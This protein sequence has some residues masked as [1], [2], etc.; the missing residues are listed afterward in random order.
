MRRLPNFVVIGAMK[1]GTTSLHTYLRAHPDVF[2]PA[3]KELDFFDPG[4]TWHRGVDW[5]RAQFDGADGS[6]AVGEASTSYSKY[7]DVDGV[8]DRLVDLVPDIRVIY[9]IRHPIERMRSQYLHEVLVGTEHAPIQTALTEHPRYVDYSRYW[10]QIE[11]YLDRVPR[12]RLLV[13]TAE[14]LRSDRRST[15]RRIYRFLGVS[16]AGWSEDLDIEHHRTAEKKVARAGLVGIHRSRAY[17]AAT[18]AVPERLKGPVRR[19]TTRRI[20]PARGRLD[21]AL[22]RQLASVLR[23]D[24]RAL[25]SF[26]GEGFHAWGL[27]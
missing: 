25:R 2:M 22:A 24:L 26:L 27:V 9:L 7:P 12:D 15:M 13:E 4:G 19:L 10:M 14:S 20:D 8:P 5:Y 18:R 3:V 21:P 23:G 11:R 6:I 17:R 16:E 1:S